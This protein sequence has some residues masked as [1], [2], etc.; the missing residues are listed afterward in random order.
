MK[1]SATDTQAVNDGLNALKNAYDESFFNTLKNKG[2]E[3]IDESI[4]HKN[5]AYWGPQNY[6]NFYS[7]HAEENDNTG[8]ETAVDNT[9]LDINDEEV[10]DMIEEIADNELVKSNEYFD[11]SDF[12]NPDITGPEID[13]SFTPYTQSFRNDVEDQQLMQA[14]TNTTE[15]KLALPESVNDYFPKTDYAG[16]A[17]HSR[18]Y[19]EQELKEI[20]EN[21]KHIN[22]YNTGNDFSSIHSEN[23]YRYKKHYCRVKVDHKQVKEGEQLNSRAREVIRGLDDKG[24]PK[25]YY[26]CNK[27]VEDM[28]E[29]IFPKNKQSDELFW[30]TGL[31]AN[32]IYDK[33][34][35]ANYKDVIDVSD[36]DK[37]QI[38]EYIDEGYIVIVAWKDKGDIGHIVLGWPESNMVI[39][40]GSTSKKN[41]LKKEFNIHKYPDRGNQIK[42]YIYSG[43]LSKN[44]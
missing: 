19:L 1:Q 11:W 44:Y 28:L 40:A 25:N 30:G 20:A 3:Y 33:L 17:F 18:F 26:Y 13:I 5:H 23:K 35:Q 10:Q 12:D 9:Y 22:N 31:T 39:G 6:Y 34:T 42:F 41:T 21:P 27:Y 43:H 32:R 29:M 14:I 37:E 16:N 4:Y 8:N 38:W 15:T 7:Y 36:Q 24:N 2:P